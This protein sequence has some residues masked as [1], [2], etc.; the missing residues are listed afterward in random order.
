MLQGSVAMG[1]AG[2][3]GDVQRRGGL[4]CV[5]ADRVAT[6]PYFYRNHNMGRSAGFFPLAKADGDRVC[7]GQQRAGRDHPAAALAAVKV[8]APSVLPPPAAG[9]AL[10]LRV[11]AAGSQGLPGELTCCSAPVRVLGTVLGAPS[12]S[13]E[14]R[15]PP[16][17]GACCKAGR[18]HASVR[19]GLCLC[20]ALAFQRSCLGAKS[21]CPRF[22]AAHPC[23]LAA[24]PCFQL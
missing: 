18:A 7:W 20:S 4:I 10:S 16:S 11:Q 23:L 17:P 19:A 22:A 14:K 13:R 24:S 1:D 15:L 6:K 2:K 12:P 8:L 3:G 21:P 5:S 9:A